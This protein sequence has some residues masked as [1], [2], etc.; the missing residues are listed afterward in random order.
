MDRQKVVENLKKL[1]S[2]LKTKKYLTGEDLKKIPKLNYYTSFHFRTLA[3]ALKAAGLP[4][5]KLAAAMNTSNEELLQ[6][7][8]DLNRELGQ[9]PTVWHIQHDEKLYKKYSNEKIVWSLYKS[10]FGGLT[11]ARELAG[12]KDK[13]LFFKEAKSASNQQ[14]NDENLPKNRFWGEAAELHVL[15][16]LL[17][18]KFQAANVPVDVGLDI[19][20]IKNNKTYYFQVKHKDLS[21]NQAIKITKSSFEKTGSGEVYYIFVLLTDKK[22]DFLI[23]PYHIINDWIREKIIEDTDDGYLIYIKHNK[24][25]E[26]HYVLKEKMLDRFL[27]NWEIIR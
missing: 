10:R 5:S 1:A 24:N 16:E 4:S 9:I 17:Y 26:E 3:N 13:S 23:I 21:N 15:A 25:G 8:K 27:N 11:K 22:R 12:I 2:Q 18:R 19:L 20:A 7:L 6:Y 14:E